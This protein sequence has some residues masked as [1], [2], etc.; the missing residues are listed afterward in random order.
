MSKTSILPSL[1]RLVA[2]AKELEDRFRWK[3]VFP[4]AH[5][6]QAPYDGKYYMLRGDSGYT[7]TPHRIV[8]ARYD[9][10]FRPKQPWV[11]Y[12]GD[13]VT[14]GGEMPTEYMELIP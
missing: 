8:V 12:A 6:S 1:A 10:K 5:N 11:D 3:T 7:R 9:P 4:L 13:S 14:D 2:E